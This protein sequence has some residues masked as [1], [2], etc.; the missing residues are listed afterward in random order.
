MGEEHVLWSCSSLEEALRENIESL[1]PLVETA[2]SRGA[3]VGE[4]VYALKK[5]KEKIEKGYLR[6]LVFL[7]TRLIGECSSRE[8]EVAQLHSELRNL[9]ER[10]RGALEEHYC[11]RGLDECVEREYQRLLATVMNAPGEARKGFA[12]S[13][14]KKAV[15]ALA[16]N[17]C[18]I[19]GLGWLVELKSGTFRRFIEKTGLRGEYRVLE[20]RRALEKIIDLIAPDIRALLRDDEA[21]S[22][23]REKTRE[24]AG[25]LRE[26]DLLNLPSLRILAGALYY[27][28]QEYVPEPQARLSQKEIMCILNT[29]ETSLRKYIHVLR[30][31]FHEPGF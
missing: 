24:L 21:L 9:Y 20:R 31:H 7:N 17:N 6:G 18:G 4:C 23:L 30:K 10:G 15:L 11:V 19:P 1:K 28:A 25:R 29:T 13:D 5:L 8:P 22:K 16:L 2:E 14:I 12:V 26:E 27:M 3:S